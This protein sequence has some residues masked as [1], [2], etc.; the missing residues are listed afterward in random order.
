MNSPLGKATTPLNR[1]F[2]RVLSHTAVVCLV[3]SAL[4]LIANRNRLVH[5]DDYL[6]A[7]LLP[8]YFQPPSQQYVVD[9]AFR[10]CRPWNWKSPSCATP[11]STE[12]YYGDVGNLGGW[13]TLEKDLGLGSSWLSRK[14]MSVKKISAKYYEAHRASVVADVALATQKDCNVRGNRMCIPRRVLADVSVISEKKKEKIVKGIFEHA[15]AAD[16]G[17]LSAGARL[18]LRRLSISKPATLSETTRIPS[19]KEL[20]EAMWGSRGYGLWVKMGTASENSIQDL[21]VLFGADAVEP[22]F[23]WKLQDA[24]LLGLGLPRMPAP[25]LT[26]KVGTTLPPSIDELQYRKDGKFKILQ[27]AD[28]HFSTG[29]GV[30][31]DPIPASSAKDCEADPRTLRFL[32]SVLD[33]ETPDLVVMT[34]DQIFGE[35]APDPQTALFKAVMPF[36]ARRIPYALTLGNHDDESTMTR[37]QIMGLAATLPYSLARA[38]DKDVD[39]FGNYHVMVTGRGMTDE[40]AAL[41]FMDSHS[42]SLD[43]K[44][45]PGYD[46][47]KPLQIEW[48]DASSSALR[49]QHAPRL[50]MA[51]FHIP[52]P[53]YR[54]LEQPLVGSVKEGVTAPN[55]NTGMRDALVRAG[56]Q[57]ATCGHD[58]ANDYC[59]LDSDPEDALGTNQIWLCYGGASGEGGYGGYGGYVRRLRVYELDA[60]SGSIDTWKRQE[61]DA[62]TVFDRQTVVSNGLVVSPAA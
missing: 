54:K 32:N 11:L 37:E 33:A 53:E 26:A 58:H 50:S 24:P 57:V 21:D 17:W 60:V 40:P 36:V 31:R 4:L 55:K 49:G 30:C 34:G 39:G 19:S 28:L 23:N 3:G 20:K 59:L 22:R 35:G 9:V 12:G 18:L 10:T 44:H 56:V 48:I 16:Q 43:P 8:E 6:Q 47:F 15:G 38:G 7:D 51:F 1:R 5:L 14:Y 45:D 62:R 46:Y 41:Y 2:L 42:Y 29:T 13:T 27:V 25:R 52:L 61:S